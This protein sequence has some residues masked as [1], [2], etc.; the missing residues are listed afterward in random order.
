MAK[1]WTHTQAFAHFGTKPRNVQWSWSARNEATKTVV[2]TLWQDEFVKDGT[3]LIYR[4]RASYAEA[5]DTR[6]GF[7][8]L[9]DNLA[10][11]ADNCDGHFRVIV[12]IAR[13]PKANPRSIRECFPNDRL[14]MKLVDFDRA[15][16]EYEA[17]SIG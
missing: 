8:E 1:V 3:R 7:R 2:V 17:V 15:T 4:R 13:D 11:A 10:W 12:A 5:S 14:V 9:I 6:P 16:G